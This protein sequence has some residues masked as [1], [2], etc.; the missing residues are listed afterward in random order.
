MSKKTP[1]N[2]AHRATGVMTTMVVISLFVAVIVIW[3]SYGYFTQ[4]FTE[5]LRSQA[6][7]RAALY[8]GNIKST[9][10]KHSVVPFLLAQD[11][12]LTAALQTENYAATS[13]RLIEV[14]DEIGT[15]SVFL[16]DISGRVV[17]SS[18]RRQIGKFFRGNPYFINALR[19]SSTVFST[20]TEEQNTYRFFFSQK[21][22]SGPKSIGVVVVEVDLRTQ[23]GLW[24][25]L[26]LLVALVN[27]QG[28]IQLSSQLEWRRRSIQSL[29][30]PTAVSTSRRV[31]DALQQTSLQ[32]F[33]F[34]DGERLFAAESEVDFRGWRINYFAST[35]NVAARVNAILALEIMGMAIVAALLFF[36]LSRRRAREFER[37]SAEGNELRALNTR[38][39]A[40]MEQ[41]QRAER[42]LQSAE[43]NLEQASKL[44][45]LGQMSAAVSHE[46]NQPLAAMRTYLAGAKLLVKRNR[47]DEAKSSFQR[48]DD[49]IARMGV[50]T[51]QLKSYARKSSDSAAEIDL[52]DC[53]SSAMAIMAPQLGKKTV[54][55]VQNLPDHKVCTLGD[56]IRVEQIIINLLRNALDALKDIPE[57]RIEINLEAGD[58]ARLSV[59]DNGPGFENPEA[60][61]EPFYTTKAPGEGVGL[62]LAISA[63]IATEMGGRL[64]AQNA[65]PLGAIFTLE[66]PLAQSK[67]E[68][69]A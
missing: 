51:K 39:S 69:A 10:Q 24:R 6:Q 32:D 5:N 58:T 21:V 43:Q 14:S 63:G 68:A 49:L 46:L 35:K 38:L 57:P 30:E 45:V 11:L 60:L 50:I 12:S 48:I 53:V 61:F 31:L 42:N 1:K 59:R 22:K 18:N 2:K 17:A 66:L 33:V 25:R 62:G 4:S 37:L 7:T 67:E 23:E 40:E 36:Y 54:R 16:L 26:G 29:M 20:S 44:A 15:A 41:R 52:R 64:M 55:I 28:E 56:N 3:G 47:L 13:Q 9:L 34:I 8:A 27:S 65:T 19:S